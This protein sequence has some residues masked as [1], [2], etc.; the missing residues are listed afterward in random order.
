MWIPLRRTSRTGAFHKCLATCTT[1]I[2]TSNTIRLQV[3]KKDSLKEEGGNKQIRK[4]S[5][6]ALLCYHFQD[7]NV[8]PTPASV[9]MTTRTESVHM[10][11]SYKY[12]YVPVRIRARSHAAL[13]HTSNLLSALYAAER[14][15]SLTSMIIIFWEMTPCGSYKILRNVGSYKSHTVSSPRRW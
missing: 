3:R 9:A 15:T 5:L 11:A 2:I 10:R 4:T 7:N 14:R 8:S 6:I 13:L 1:G 12:V